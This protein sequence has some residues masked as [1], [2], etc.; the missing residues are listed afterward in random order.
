MRQRLYAH[1]VWTTRGRA[2][3]IDARRARFLNRLLRVIG[4]QHRLLILD[5]GMVSTHLHLLVRFHPMTRL[6][7][8]L[9]RLKGTSSALTEKDCRSNTLP[10]LRWARGY[11]VD[12][13][14]F[15][16]L[17]Q[18]RSYVR[19][20]ATRHPDEAIQGWENPPPVTAARELEWW[21]ENRRSL[22]V[23]YESTDSG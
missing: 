10:P 17:E 6:S 14:G 23:W 4:R 19:D 16:S 18:A 5:L 1:I 3:L 9:Q 7:E 8:S 22:R 11:S 15:R 12:T 21:S 20:Q 13:V 2:P